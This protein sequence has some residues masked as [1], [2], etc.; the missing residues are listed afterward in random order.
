MSDEKV[1]ILVR[2]FFENGDIEVR[3]RSWVIFLDSDAR[4]DNVIT[5]EDR[6]VV[7]EGGE[8]FLCFKEKLIA[9]Q[10]YRGHFVD[11]KQFRKQHPGGDP[12]RGPSPQRPYRDHRDDR[13]HAR[14]TFDG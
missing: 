10:F 7:E 4:I 14:S 12:I 6:R 2:M 3:P 13:G 5:N 11:A 9:L 8:V 1:E